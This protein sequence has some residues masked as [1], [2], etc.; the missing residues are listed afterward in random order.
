VV[1]GS[2]RRDQ[3]YPT[4]APRQ[5]LSVDIQ[6]CWGGCDPNAGEVRIAPALFYI[7]A[8]LQYPANA[9][10]GVATTITP[11]VDLWSGGQFSILSGSLPA[12][13]SLNPATG[14]ISGHSRCRATPRSPSA[15]AP[16][17]TSPDWSTSP[18]PQINVASPSI[19]LTYPPVTGVVGQYLS[20]QPN[21]TGQTG[22]SVDKLVV[23]P[24]LQGLTFRS[25][26]NLACPRI[27]SILKKC[28]FSELRPIARITI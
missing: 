10:A 17:S 2:L 16:E 15:T 26:F 12:G 23:G 20:V 9:T 28:C 18:R 14:V 5:V 4:T 24:F 3:R 6:A 13:T 19:P 22:T 7:L 1:Q 8:R 21:V 27:A 25:R 11:T